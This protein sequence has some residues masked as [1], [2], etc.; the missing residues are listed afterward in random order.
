M[1]HVAAAVMTCAGLLLSNVAQSQT[2]PGP[3][4]LN[5]Q[6]VLTF[7]GKD[8]PGQRCNNNIQIAAEIANAYRVPIQIVPSGVAGPKVPAPAVFYGGQLIAADG[9]AHNGMVSYQIVADTLEL[10]G[11]PKHAK[12]GRLF[13]QSV[14]QDFDQL[15]NAIKG[16]K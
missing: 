15:K 6:K 13:E 14:R 7:V 11:A 12:S 3:V 4:D 8:P 2:A 10:E 5:G 9:G 16:A 1:N